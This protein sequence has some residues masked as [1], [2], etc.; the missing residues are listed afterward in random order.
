MNINYE[1]NNNISTIGLYIS[2]AFKTS[3]FNSAFDSYAKCLYSILQSILK[4]NNNAKITE[5]INTLINNETNLHIIILYAIQMIKEKSLSDTISPVSRVNSNALIREINNTRNAKELMSLMENKRNWLYLN[6]NFKYLLTKVIETNLNEL[7]NDYLNTK[8]VIQHRINIYND[9]LNNLN[10]NGD[11][12][13]QI[14]SI[15]YQQMKIIYLLY[16]CLNLVVTVDNDNDNG[17]DTHRRLKEELFQQ[18]SQLEMKNNQ[19]KTEV[20]NKNEYINNLKDNISVMETETSQKINELNTFLTNANVEKNNLSL[21]IQQLYIE[22]EE[23]HQQRQRQQQFEETITQVQQLRAEMEQN[24][25]KEKKEK[26]EKTKIAQELSQKLEAEIKEKNEKIKLV[27]ELNQKLETVIKEKN[28]EKIKLVE[29]LS[30]K[31]ETEIKEKKTKK[32][33]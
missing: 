4:Y 26:D 32:Y 21:K 5:N 22:I 33:K 11:N 1:N 7:K 20:N 17:H 24:L 8:E 30:Q 15:W 3:D 25:E 29:E 27:E 19:L 23:I 13:Y 2:Q 6:C 28:E 9:I 14:N 16:R 12:V 31:L 10:C 18:K